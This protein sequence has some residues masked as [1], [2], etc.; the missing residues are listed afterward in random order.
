MSK[1][2]SK[3]I[4]DNVI[5]LN[6]INSNAHISATERHIYNIY[7]LTYDMYYRQVDMSKDIA[8]Y[9]KFPDIISTSLLFL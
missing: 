5:M 2:T 4:F 7:N 6:V 3:F 8:V 1:N 9:K